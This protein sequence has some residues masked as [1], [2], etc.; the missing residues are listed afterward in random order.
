LLS[1]LFPPSSDAVIL[2]STA[3]PTRNT[4]APGGA[5]TNSGWQY[6]GTWGLFLGTPIGPKHFLTATHVGGAVGDKFQFRGVD[7]TATASFPDTESDLCLW[8]IC[9]TFPDYAPVFS[10]GTEI[11][12]A[13]VVIG[14]GTQRGSEVVTSGLQGGLKGWQW[15]TADAV[16]RWGTN[17]V[18]AVVDG[19]L[20]FEVT[21]AG[22]MLKCN[23]DA[24]DGGDEAHLSGGDSGGAMFILDGSVWKLGGIHYSVDGPYNT[25]ASGVGFFA[26]IFDEGGLYTGGEGKWTLRPDL[27][28]NLPSAFYSTRI[29]SRLPWINSVLQSAQADAPPV[30]RSS[31]EVNGSYEIVT[32]AVVDPTAKTVTTPVPAANQ[33]YRLQACDS[34]RITGIMVQGVLLVISY[35]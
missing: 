29:S 14:R 1:V 31:S 18:T 3:D 24:G 30:L 15:G 11:G 23:F 13:V 9:G 4:T 16:Q 17:I 10:V 7:Y 22:D 28:V 21:G 6:E 8:R 19:N 33:F 20:I 35:E 32:G 34:L 26:A 27:P 12:K 25:S 2:N 5:L